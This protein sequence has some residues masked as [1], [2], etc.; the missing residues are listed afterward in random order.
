MGRTTKESEF[1]FQQRQE[2]F[3]F[4]IMSIPAMRPAEPPIQWVPGVKRLER[5]DD[6]S[7]PSGAKVKNG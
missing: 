6:H 7:S 4:S 2:I 1:C 3:L 5:E